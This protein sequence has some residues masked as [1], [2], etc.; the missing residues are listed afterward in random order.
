MAVMAADFFDEVGYSHIPIEDTTER[1]PAVSTTM[2]TT[3]WSASDAK[4]PSSS[5]IPRHLARQP[6]QWLPGVPGGKPVVHLQTSVEPY[7]S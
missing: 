2:E 1:F 4:R 7:C 5:A 6:M 3:P